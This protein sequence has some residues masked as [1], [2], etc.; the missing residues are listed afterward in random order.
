MLTGS[1]CICEEDEEEGGG[2]RRQT[3]AAGFNHL[4]LVYHPL[5][6]QKVCKAG[7][8]SFLPLYVGEQLPVPAILKETLHTAVRACVC[9]RERERAN[10][11]PL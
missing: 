2:D 11:Y 8:D 9:E 7:S 6:K 4:T 5:L 3:G 10:V 1:V